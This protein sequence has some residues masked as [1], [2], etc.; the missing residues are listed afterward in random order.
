MHRPRAV[1]DIFTFVVHMYG[2]FIFREYNFAT[3]FLTRSIRSTFGIKKRNPGIRSTVSMKTHSTGLQSASSTPMHRSI[4]ATSVRNRHNVVDDGPE[5]IR[6][7]QRRSSDCPSRTCRICYETVQSRTDSASGESIYESSNPA[8]GRLIRPCKCSGSQK[9]IHEA[10]LQAYRHHSPLQDSYSKCATC[11]YR[12]RPAASRFQSF[13]AHP[14]T[15]V[16]VTSTIVAL[17]IFF[18]GYI[19]IPLLSYTIR[20]R[21]TLEYGIQVTSWYTADRGWL[22]HF[23]QGAVLTGLIGIAVLI[24]DV[25]E[26]MRT[27]VWHPPLWFMGFLGTMA[28]ADS[29]FGFWVHIAWGIVRVA[30]WIWGVIGSWCRRRAEYGGGLM[31]LEYHGDSVVVGNGI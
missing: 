13:L 14:A 1:F 20:F 29:H 15:L 4:H 2:V 10:C 3:A 22:D 16:L 12:Y 6:N 21:Q 11:G 24:G 8:D 19:A 27:R 5:P 9:Y 26:M 28:A 31:V 30:Y 25:I 17:S 18:G 23:A 7:T